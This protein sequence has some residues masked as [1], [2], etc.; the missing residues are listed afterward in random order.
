[1]DFIRGGYE[2][3][4]SGYHYFL[5][6]VD[7]HSRYVWVWFL[8]SKDKVAC[9]ATIG[10]FKNYVENQFGRKL[11]RMRTDNGIREFAN[12]E[13]NLIISEAGIQP[14]YHKDRNGVSG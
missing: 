2:R 1:L 12:S 11:K 9:S 14:P 3:S 13:W 4:P 10:E 6:F 7:D 8:K 5:V